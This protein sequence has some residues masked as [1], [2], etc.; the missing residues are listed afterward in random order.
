VSVGDASNDAGVA[1]SD[2]TNVSNWSF[3]DTTTVDPNAS[4]YFGAAFDGRY[5]Y[6]SPVQGSPI[7][8]EYDTHGAFTAAKS[9]ATFVLG[10]DAGTDNR[11]V[12]AAYDGRF[13]YLPPFGQSAPVMARYDTQGTY[14]S[15]SSWTSTNIATVVTN[16][17]TGV[18]GAV[19]AS[20][21]VYLAPYGNS[22]AVAYDT[23]APLAMASSWTS[24]DATSLVG[25]GYV[26]CSGASDG[27]MVY[28]APFSNGMVLR[29][30][31]SAP[32]AAA[33]SWSA[34]DATTLDPRATAFEGAVFDG[35]FVYFIPAGAIFTATFAIRYDT[36]KTFSDGASWE[37]FDIKN[38]NN[39]AGGF[40]GGAFD[41]RYVYYVPYGG[42]KGLSGLVARFD[43]QAASFGTASAWQTIDLTTLNANAQ[44]YATAAFD[45]RYLYLSPNLSA[46]SP[47][48]IVARFDARTPPSS[49]A[50][51]S[52]F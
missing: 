18:A 44:G 41:G 31:A 51:S 26:A 30:D 46:G 16:A 36:H 32:F 48:H 21:H 5:V 19:F 29:Y 50:P 35:Q 11:F 3:F 34:F 14:T 33:P 47:A 23:T 2:M 52:F 20:N 37:A 6:F 24:F 7:A 39:N 38:A 49:T 28:F 22:V 45:G 1:Y 9:W 8:L 15:A 25:A 17:S 42:A 43:T 10:D 27:K 4:G 12:G 40:V 13:L